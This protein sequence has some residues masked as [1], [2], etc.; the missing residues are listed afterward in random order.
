[1]YL[2]LQDYRPDTPRVPSVISVREG[3]LLS[4]VA[5]AA[6]LLVIMFAPTEWL[7]ATP[8]QVAMVREDEPV[9]FVEMAP[10]VDQM[11]LAK[12]LAEQSDQDRRSATVDRAPIPENEAPRSVGNTPEKVVGSPDE[13]TEDAAPPATP[14]APA[15]PQPDNATALLREAEPPPAPTPPAPTAGRALRNLQRY[16]RDE[17]Y[18]NP[19]GGAT[20]PSADIQFDAKGVDFGPWLRRFRAQIRRNWLIPQVAELA[21]GRVV[22]QFV[23]LRNGSL[24]EMRIVRPA[25]I[26]ALTSSAVNALKLSNPTVPLPP[27]YPDDQILFTVTFLYN[28]PYTP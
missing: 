6:V 16:L 1:M 5:H 24:I 25:G 22:V 11:E 20:E 18:D 9:R 13:R 17:N 4:L 28:E 21:R 19:E 3:V 23:V 8:E 26:D 12:R 2:D 10:V 15:P 7:E 27:E 14:P